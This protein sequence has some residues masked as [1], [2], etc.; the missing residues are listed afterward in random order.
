MYLIPGAKPGFRTR[1]RTCLNLIPVNEKYPPDDV[2]VRAMTASGAEP[3]L[4]VTS[5]PATA[6]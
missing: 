3:S 5:A 4:I 2:V 6:R 1:M